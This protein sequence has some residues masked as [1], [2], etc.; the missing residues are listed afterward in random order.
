MFEEPPAGSPLA[1]KATLLTA[2]LLQKANRVLPLSV[3]AKIQVI[4]RTLLLFIHPLFSMYVLSDIG[5]WV[6]FFFLS[7]GF[8]A[9]V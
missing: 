1:R 4:A 7:I 6:F 5:G 8:A 9:G 2:E 3:A